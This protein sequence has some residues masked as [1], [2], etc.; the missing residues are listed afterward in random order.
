M[1]G[2][3]RTRRFSVVATIIER[4]VEIQDCLGEIQ[5]VVFTKGFI[6]TLF[7]DWKGRLIGPDLVFILGEIY[8]LQGEIARERREKFGRI[9]E[10]FAAEETAGQLNDILSGQQADGT[11]SARQRPG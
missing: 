3:L 10:R 7:D 5:D 9:W 4:T 6:D 11:G 2:N 1:V 8:Q